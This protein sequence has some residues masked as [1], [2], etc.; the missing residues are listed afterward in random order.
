MTINANEG[1]R[2]VSTRETVTCKS[3]GVR[4]ILENG[5]PIEKCCEQFER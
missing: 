5:E 4:V 1:P 2:A 3:C